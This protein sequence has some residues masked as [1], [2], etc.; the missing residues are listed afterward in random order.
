MY[1]PSFIAMQHS[2]NCRFHQTHIPYVAPPAFRAMYP[3]ATPNEADYFGAATAMD[4]QV[5]RNE[6]EPLSPK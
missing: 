4:A 2:R 1:K 6:G 3:N 5:R